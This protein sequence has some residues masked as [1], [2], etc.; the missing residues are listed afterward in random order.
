MRVNV[1]LYEGFGDPGEHSPALLRFPVREKPQTSSF[2]GLMD[3]VTE[4]HA[5]THTRTHAALS[6]RSFT[7]QL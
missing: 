5:H 6:H 3:G 4:H 2:T 7:Q 1:E